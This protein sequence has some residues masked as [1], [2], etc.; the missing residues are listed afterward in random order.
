MRLMKNDDPEARRRGFRC[1]T[2]GD[3]THA[4]APGFSLWLI[5]PEDD[6]ACP[7]CVEACV[8]CEAILFPRETKTP[9]EALCREC[10]VA[11]CRELQEESPS[12]AR[13]RLK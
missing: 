9:A 13:K 4:D 12:W 7:R 8:E 3:A 2:C 5:N 6:V 1:D 11:S 10:A